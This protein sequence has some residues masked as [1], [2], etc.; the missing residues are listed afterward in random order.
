MRYEEIDSR[1]QQIMDRFRKPKPG[2]PTAGP[3]PTPQ[4]TLD[5]KKRKLPRP[6]QPVDM[7]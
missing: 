1:H 4:P 6:K 7:R 5:T 2:G 3:L